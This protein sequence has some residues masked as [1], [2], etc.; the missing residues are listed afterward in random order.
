MDLYSHSPTGFH[1]VVFN[2][3]SAGRALPLP[4]GT[5]YRWYMEPSMDLKGEKTKETEE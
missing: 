1:G 3:F 2:W 4:N 5:D